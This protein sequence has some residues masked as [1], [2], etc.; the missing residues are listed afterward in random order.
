MRKQLSSCIVQGA[1]SLL[2]QSS[3]KRQITTLE[4]KELVRYLGYEATQ[5]EIS[6]GMTDLADKCEAAGDALHIKIVNE[7]GN[8]FKVFSDEVILDDVLDSN[9]FQFRT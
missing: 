1:A 4:V 2:I 8:Q 5:N 7:N 3:P 6:E 9:A